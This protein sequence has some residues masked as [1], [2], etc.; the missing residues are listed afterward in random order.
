[1]AIIFSDLQTRNTVQ[2][3]ADGDHPVGVG[4]VVLNDELGLLSESGLATAINSYIASA[5]SGHTVSLSK[6]HFA[7]TSSSL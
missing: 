6:T 7:V 2:G 3:N 1:M 4:F 5:Y